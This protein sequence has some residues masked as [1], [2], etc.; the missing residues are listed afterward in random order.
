MFHS[1]D[2]QLVWNDACIPR[3]NTAPASRLGLLSTSKML[4]LALNIVGRSTVRQNLPSSHKM[5]DRWVMWPPLCMAVLLQWS[6]HSHHDRRSGLLAMPRWRTAPPIASRNHVSRAHG[7]YCVICAWRR[8][9]SSFYRLPCYSCSVMVPLPPA[10]LLEFML[11]SIAK[12]GN[13]VSKSSGVWQFPRI[14]MMYS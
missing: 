8:S 6:V 4:R 10:L 11:I 3:H 1:F 2:T 7:T 12:N 13:K 9:A 14:I 5:F